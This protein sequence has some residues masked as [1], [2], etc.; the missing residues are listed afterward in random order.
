[1]ISFKKLRIWTLAFI[2]SVS[3]SQ[4]NQTSL[5]DEEKYILEIHHALRDHH[6]KKDSTKF[7]NQ[8]ADHFISVNKGNISTPSH[9]ELITRYSSYFSSVEF[10]KWDDVSE[11]IIRF[12]DD[13]TMAYSVVDKMVVVTYPDDDGNT[14]R[15]T[16]H[17]AWTAI[18]RKY[19][20]E[21]KIDCVTSTNKPETS[22][23]TGDRE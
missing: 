12:S 14:I 7:V 17:F 1:M 16:T 19:E 13:A 10:E 6:F 2:V 3:C 20:G 5:A 4:I 23:P 21:W 15:G 9:E 11:P 18:Y 8:L 22:S